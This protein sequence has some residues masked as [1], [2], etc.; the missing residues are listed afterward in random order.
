MDST[1]EILASTAFYFLWKLPWKQVLEAYFASKSEL[2]EIE[3]QPLDLKRYFSVA[4]FV[5]ISFPFMPRRKCENLFIRA[6]G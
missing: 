2:P 1:E 5:P 3:Q 6:L 4:S